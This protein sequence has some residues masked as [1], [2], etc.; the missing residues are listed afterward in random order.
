MKSVGSPVFGFI[1][2]VWNNP[3]PKPVRFNVLRNCLGIIISVSTLAMS[4][5]ALVPLTVVNG[6][7]VDGVVTGTVSVVEPTT[8]AADGESDRGMGFGG[9]SV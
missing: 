3:F 2:R 6:G 7:I 5:G 8:V 9:G 1:R 4:R